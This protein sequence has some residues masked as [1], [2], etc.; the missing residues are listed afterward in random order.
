MLLPAGF[1]FLALLPQFI[2]GLFDAP[3]LRDAQLLDRT[4]QLGDF[5]LLGGAFGF[6]LLGDAA[7]L[8]FRLFAADFELLALAGKAFFNLLAAPAAAG[9]LFRIAL[10]LGLSM[11]Q[12]FLR[13]RRVRR[14]PLRVRRDCDPAILVAAEILRAEFHACAA[15]RRTPDRGGRIRVRRPVRRQPNLPPRSSAARRTAPEDSIRSLPSAR[16]GPTRAIGARLD[17]GPSESRTL[18]CAAESAR[19]SCSSMFAIHERRWLGGGDSRQ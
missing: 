6:E 5:V 15:G 10:R 19:D 9:Q 7:A 8:V 16:S 11:P 14:A 2:A 3:L 13:A 1:E 17:A 12:R 4:A 18:A